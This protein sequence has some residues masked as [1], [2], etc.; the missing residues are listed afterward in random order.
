M[1]RTIIENKDEANRKIAE[2]N[3]QVLLVLLT[4]PIPVHV[5]F[6]RNSHLVA[7]FL[8]SFKNM[9]TFLSSGPEPWYL[10][11]IPKFSRTPTPP[12]QV[13]K[14][15]G[16]MKKIE[17]EVVKLRSYLEEVDQGLRRLDNRV[18]MMKAENDAKF[19]EL[20]QSLADVRA[21]VEDHAPRLE[22]VEMLAEKTDKDLKAGI[23]M[24][25]KKIDELDGRTTK[26]FEA[27]ESKVEVVDDRLTTL[28]RKFKEA[29]IEGL[30]RK[31]NAATVKIAEHDKLHEEHVKVEKRLDEKCIRLREDVDGIK[32]YCDATFATKI[33]VTQIHTELKIEITSVHT[34]LKIFT[35]TVIKKYLTKNEFSSLQD[36]F[37]TNIVNHMADE[38][39][40]QREEIYDRIS[41]VQERFAA[42][43]EEVAKSDDWQ[44][45]VA[46]LQRLVDDVEGIGKVVALFPSATSCCRS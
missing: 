22:A 43:I 17:G 40:H 10:R 4:Q 13:H 39:V 3:E 38:L 35:E 45:C 25:T 44:T 5:F 31:V 21:I 16:Q 26:R 20:D 2:T 42:E 24:V 7:F 32:P 11:L 6:S 28:E 30:T 18:T 29:D 19:K 14:L 33:T 9:L 8:A 36:E 1:N 46:G 23:A 12:C 27:I 37:H 41:A 34:E 15:K